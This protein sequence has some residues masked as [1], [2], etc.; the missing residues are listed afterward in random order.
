MCE[1]WVL[2]VVVTFSVLCGVYHTRDREGI[3]LLHGN[4]F[5]VRPYAVVTVYIFQ[6]FLNV[7]RRL[8]DHVDNGILLFLP[9][10]YPLRYVEASAI[11]EWIYV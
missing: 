5:H 9:D 2:L 10:I 1:M 4:N 6:Y 8:R 11:R 3:K 7:N